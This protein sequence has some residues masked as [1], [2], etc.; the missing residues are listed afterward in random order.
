MKWYIEFEKIIVST[1]RDLME[2]LS[3]HG[4]MKIS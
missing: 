4:I 3:N 2:E 1:L